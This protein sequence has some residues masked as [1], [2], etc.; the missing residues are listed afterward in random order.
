MRRCLV[1]QARHAVDAGVDVLQIREPDLEAGE[2]EELVSE[3]V[4]LAAGTRTRVLVNDRADI[5]LAG[6]AQGVHLKYDSTPPEAVRAIAPAGFMIGGSV[7]TPAEAQAAAPHVDYLIAGTV[8]SS[9]SKPEGHRL[10]GR[11]GLAQ[12]A[13]TVHVPVLA[14]GGVTL[15][16]CG[17]VGE[18]GAAGV[19]AIGLFMDLEARTGGCR[20]IPLSARV[21]TARERFATS[22]SAS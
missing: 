20:A 7:H 13:S 21:A 9:A 10:L 22:N 2:L 8:W 15:G 11:E 19:A 3:V 5:A 17:A 12:I 4:A 6:G 16:S 18:A 14:I 1:Q